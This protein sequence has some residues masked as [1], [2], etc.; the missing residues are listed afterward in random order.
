MNIK[1]ITGAT[2][3]FNQTAIK[4]QSKITLL[5][6]AKGFGAWWWFFSILSI[7]ASYY[8]FIEILNE[9]M[10]TAEPMAILFVSFG[11]AFILEVFK[12]LAIMWVFADQS[13]STQFLSFIVLS[14]LVVASFAFHYIGVILAASSNSALI[15]DEEVSRQRLVEDR[16]YELKIQQ[17]KIN[18]EIAKV[19]NN[20]SIK[21][22]L[23][24]TSTIA[25]NNQ[26]I[27]LV[28]KPNS[29]IALSNARIK[30]H[31]K[32]Q[33]DVNIALL[34]ILCLAEIFILFSLLSKYIFKENA[35]KNLLIFTSV[36]EE[37][38]DMI[39]SFWETTTKDFVKN[40]INELNQ[41]KVQ[42]QQN[43]PTPT[44]QENQTQPSNIPLPYFSTYTGYKLNNKGN[45]QTP[46]NNGA[47]GKS[48]TVTPNTTMTIYPN[49][50]LAK[51]DSDNN[52]NN[53]RMSEKNSQ[54]KLLEIKKIIDE[55]GNVWLHYKNWMVMEQNYFSCV[56]SSRVG[57]PLEKG[58]TEAQ[59]KYKETKTFEIESPISEDKYKLEWIEK[60]EEMNKKY[61][62]VDF[63][64]AE[65][66]NEKTSNIVEAFN[67]KVPAID[68]K[69][70]D[71]D[72]QKLL[73][74]LFDNGAITINQNLVGR[75]HVL[76][77]VG[78]M[79]K[80]NETLSLLYEK[81]FENGLID[82]K[83]VNPNNP[84]NKYIALAELYH[85][86]WQEKK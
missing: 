45:Y 6:V 64:E 36:K 31:E 12:H 7:Y 86:N 56:I 27:Q 15:V 58:F 39:S 38:S 37:L 74:E 3:E 61:S 73:R 75:R 85:Q 78:K 81:L 41:L 32:K 62:N 49:T 16:N 28:T 46:Q 72:E 13:D 34:M 23:E 69:V 9:G 4:Q 40:S 14:I 83:S 79:K 76:R 22:D 17:G 77:A 48:D 8:T 24:A 11:L 20:K 18:L 5:A 51:Y 52:Q 44:N 29:N 10:P 50:Y 1:T 70:Y 2:N 21:D 57:D 66:I 60:V 71:E 55:D 26:Y 53:R 30:V 33:D 82:K 84:I 54:E 65:M 59:L 19:F 80:K 67:E 42:N 68:L 35:D 43:Y 25:S 63:V 47:Y